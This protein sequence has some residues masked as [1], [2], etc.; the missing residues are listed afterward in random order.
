MVVSSLSRRMVRTVALI[1]G[2][3]A[4]ITSA[5]M[6][7]AAG[8]ALPYAI[9]VTQN[10]DEGTDFGPVLTATSTTQFLAAVTSTWREV[11]AS[12]IPERAAGVAREIAL[13]HPDLVGL[14]EVT[15]WYT[16]PLGG[17]PTTLQYDALQ[18]LLTALAQDG[19]HYG[20]VAST[21]ESQFAAP[22][23]ADGV[24]VGVK[25]HDVILARTDLGSSL[26]IANVQQ[27]NYVHQ[28]ILSTI[29]GTITI[30][31]GWA[32]ADVTLRGSIFR[33]VTSHFETAAAVPIQLLEAG[34]LLAGPLETSLPVV[35]AGDFN[36][37]AAGGPDSP[38]AYDSLVSGG[39]ADAWSTTRPDSAGY[40]WPLHLEDPYSS[41]AT[42]TE[43]IDLV[44]TKGGVVP[45][46]AALLGNSSLFLTPSGLWPSDHAGVGA[47]IES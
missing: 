9:V 27:Q 25:D 29:V 3:G 1:A 44:L 17:A 8:P 13:V 2:V 26:S 32:S 46:G 38:A 45:L 14:Q 11:Q 24:T 18:S 36:S 43:R 19:V 37:A 33:F 16:G 12:N 4:L 6:P 20:V 23:F 10:M 21:P 47:L 15:Q 7:A 40:T 35:L 5:A 30:V 42:P 28:L 22:D 31:R 39:L 34:E 41:P